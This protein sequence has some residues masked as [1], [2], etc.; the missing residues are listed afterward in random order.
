MVNDEFHIIYSVLQESMY[1]L[2]N[3]RILVGEG[4][5]P[6]LANVIIREGE[7]WR[8]DRGL[9]PKKGSCIDV[10]GG[11]VIP[12]FFNSHT[13]LGDAVLG[14]GYVGKSQPQVVGEGGLKHRVRELPKGEVRRAIQGAKRHMLRTGTLAHCDFREGGVEGIELLR[15]VESGWPKSI[16]LGR[17]DGDP[18]DEV[19]RI[20]DGLGF[21]DVG[22]A[23]KFRHLKLPPG[24]HISMH[25]A[26]LREAEEASRRETGKT[27]VQ[28]ALDL[29]PSFLVH[30]IWATREDYRTLARKR[31]PLVFCPRAN[32]LLGC[33]VPP[34]RM[35]LEEDVRF[36]LGTDNVMVC[37]PDMFSELSAAWRILRC[38]DPRAGEDEAKRILLS[39][40]VHPAQFFHAEWGALEEGSA[41]TFLVLR[42]G[43]LKG[44]LS[45]VATILNRA[46]AMNLWQ[47]CLGGKP[48]RLPPPQEI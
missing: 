32:Q 34:L 39:A 9:P 12:P 36:F 26:E 4:L 21:A 23:E 29:D 24:K 19:V 17:P 22:S 15:G 30:G 38:S 31:I 47:I 5:E 37:D 44:T 42:G 45:P 27:E 28:R 10:K 18:V 40:T 35:A 16:V 46:T 13:H 3:A 43:N 14:E 7:I 20:S 41:A 2:R 25:V 33:G 1:I 48:L 8:I 11:F 6:A